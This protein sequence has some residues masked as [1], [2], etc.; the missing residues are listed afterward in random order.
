MSNTN[1][2]TKR[3]L[4]I[5]HNNK[6]Q[7]FQQRSEKIVLLKKQLENIQTKISGSSNY[8]ELYDER[9]AIKKELEDLQSSNNEVDYLLNTAPILFKYY[10]II[11]KGNGDEMAPKVSEKSILNFFIK[12][13]EPSSHT[14][15]EDRASLL[16]KYMSYTDE[17]Y[18]KL[19]ESNPNYVC[20]CCGSSNMNIMLNDG[21]VF[22]NDCSSVEYII[23][24]HDR[25][26]YKDPPKTL[27]E[28]VNAIKAVASRFP[29]FAAWLV[30]FLRKNWFFSKDKARV[31]LWV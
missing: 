28:I 10:D 22:C 15:K 13:K 9:D 12:N 7:E 17:N 19:V 4:D 27:G 29:S 5:Q 26:S 1:K 21:M 16:E 2:P 8:L 24:D 18:V 31:I 6:I 23:V 14:P 3:T 30:A 11:E 20:G 25:P